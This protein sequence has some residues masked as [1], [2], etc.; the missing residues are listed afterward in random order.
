VLDL[1]ADPD[2]LKASLIIID[3]DYGQTKISGKIGNY[4]DN[5][6]GLE[7][8]TDTGS[9]SVRIGD[10]TDIFLVTSKDENGGSKPIEVGDLMMD[11]YAD[12]YG[13]EAPDNC[14]DADTIIAYMLD[15]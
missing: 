10:K 8:V 15:N 6:C 14:F 11:Q 13:R 5:V 9:R 7:L 4:P 1:G 3:M 2:I 12:V